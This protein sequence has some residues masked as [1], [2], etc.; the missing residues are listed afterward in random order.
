VRFYFARR[1]GDGFSQVIAAERIGP[2]VVEQWIE[3][4]FVGHFT[5]AEWLAFHKTLGTI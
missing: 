2:H 5:T 1:R 4:D 3:F